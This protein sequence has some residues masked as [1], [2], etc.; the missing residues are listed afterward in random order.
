MGFRYPT[1]AAELVRGGLTVG[2][3]FKALYGQERDGRRDGAIGYLTRGALDRTGL[4][5]QAVMAAM[6][7][8]IRK[9][10]YGDL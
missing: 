1:A 8:R 3:A 2:A 9:E 10:L 6:V 4:A 5:E 7:P